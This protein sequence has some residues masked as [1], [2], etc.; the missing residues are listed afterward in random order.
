MA[1]RPPAGADEPGAQ[2]PDGAPML[3]IVD[4]AEA[5]CVELLHAKTMGRLAVVRQGKPEIFPVN[6]AVHDRTVVFRTGPGAKLEGAGLGSVAFEVDDLDPTSHE[7]WVVE[8]RGVGREVTEGLDEE[9][10]QDRALS[11]TPWVRGPK[12]HWIAVMDPHISGRRLVPHS[13]SVDEES[14]R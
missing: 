5:E 4:I 9:S 11:V 6:Y 12:E 2:D 8:V 1:R 13:A 10:E 14:E 3:D 7:G